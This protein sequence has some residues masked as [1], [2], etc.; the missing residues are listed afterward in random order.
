[1]SLADELEKL[2]ELRSSGALTDQEFEQAKMKLLSFPVAEGRIRR[3]EREDSLGRAANKYVSFRIVMALIGIIIFLIIFL[4]VFL[5]LFS[6][7][8][9]F[10]EGQF[11]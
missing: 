5:P 8:P 3:N 10:P 7:G 6:S 2:R 11:P 9:S 4:T 1:M